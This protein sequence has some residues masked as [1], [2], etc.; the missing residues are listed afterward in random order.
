MGCVVC[1]TIVVRPTSSYC[2]SH[3]R[4]EPV[5][6]DEERSEASE[7]EGILQQEAPEAITKSYANKMRL[8]LRN[9]KTWKGGVP[10]TEGQRQERLAK[11]RQTLQRREAE[12]ARSSEKRW[13]FKTKLLQQISGDLK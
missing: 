9:G 11:L 5:E 1:G 6:V 2:F 4:E 8:E 7:A 12:E 10:L 13:F 3:F